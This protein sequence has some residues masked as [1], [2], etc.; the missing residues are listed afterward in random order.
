MQLFN[1]LTKSTNSLPLLLG[2]TQNNNV[3]RKSS[4]STDVQNGRANGGEIDLAGDARALEKV[5]VLFVK[6]P[7][8]G[9]FEDLKTS[10]YNSMS[11]YIVAMR[12]GPNFNA[13]PI[14]T[15]LDL[16]RAFDTGSAF[17]RSSPMLSGAS[18][19]TIGATLQPVPRGLA[20]KVDSA[21]PVD[22]EERVFYALG[23]HNAGLG[24][25]MYWVES[26][27]EVLR[28][29]DED[30]IKKANADA[31]DQ[32]PHLMSPSQKIALGRTSVAFGGDKYALF[33]TANDVPAAGR[34]VRY[35]AARAASK[36]PW[37]LEQL[38][39]SPEY[40]DLQLRS[41]AVRDA[42]AQQYAD[43]HNLK[44][45]STGGALCPAHT[46]M[47]YSASLARDAAHGVH[48]SLPIHETRESRFYVLYHDASDASQAS[49]GNVLLHHG[50]MGG[51]T[52][53]SHKR[54]GGGSGTSGGGSSAGPWFRPHMMSLMPTHS[55]EAY[56]GHTLAKA[57]HTNRDDSTKKAFKSRVVW[58]SE[59]GDRFI[60]S[61]SHEVYYAMTDPHTAEWLTK[62]S[63]TDGRA[64]L[65]LEQEHY[66]LIAGQL[67]NISTVH[68]SIDELAQLARK[69]ATPQ[70]IP[71]SFDHPVVARIPALYSQVLRTAAYPV[72]PASIFR[73]IEE[74]KKTPG[75]FARLYEHSALDTPPNNPALFADAE[76]YHVSQYNATPLT[77]V[78]NAG[79]AALQMMTPQEI[80]AIRAQVQQNAKAPANQTNETIIYLDKELLRLLTV[81]PPVS[82]GQ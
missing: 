28:S 5:C 39:E 82:N 34:L 35:T 15:P 61:A 66:T 40:S 49:D 53:L 20:V 52:M 36:A 16:Q 46:T 12:W 6:H 68:M 60:H 64:P 7:R 33:V 10:I 4:M 30:A 73:N 8:V 38:L 43:A 24:T 56:E 79:T 78:R 26:V 65:P 19:A 25:S 54:A 62:L 69:K 76:Q 55:I 70:S 32:L 75:S 57:L 27:P 44:L 72:S 42:F 2:Q 67:N 51:H 13:T 3:E 22:S 80:D 47:A 77:T 37:L 23:G 58:H 31:R 18:G 11:P 74:R 71:V 21:M 59:L 45:A 50:I 9:E 63:P 48:D 1:I 41:Q 14:A 81:P 29:G 17:G